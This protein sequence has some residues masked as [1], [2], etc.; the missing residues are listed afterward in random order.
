MVGGQVGGGLESPL[1][2][3]LYYFVLRGLM[4]PL[5]KEQVFIE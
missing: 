2:E 4:S 1:H 3:V 5:G